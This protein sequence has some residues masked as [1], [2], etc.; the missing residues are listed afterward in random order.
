M[1][2]DIFIQAG[3]S[4]NE[5]IIYEYLLGSGQSTVG[6]IIKNTPI[7]RGLAYNILN[8]LKEKGLVVE[9]DK[10]KIASFS[11]NHPEK[12]REYVEKKGE[13]AA[14]AKNILEANLPAISSTFNLVSGKPGVRY[15][16]GLDGVKKAMEDTLTAKSEIRT[17]IDMEVTVKYIDKLN[18]QY[19]EKREKL[20][21]SK[22]IIMVE[23]E[24]SRNYLKNYHKAVTDARFIDG[25]LPQ[26]G[27]AIQIYDNKVSFVNLDENKKIAVIIEDKSIYETQK[28]IFDFVWEKSRPVEN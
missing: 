17:Y 19:A 4:E 27:S 23:S 18:R 24:F 28:T 16:E 10:S 11:A 1:Y 21:I 2:Q 15:F 12:L 25:N 5:A 8:G 14:K 7:K 13:E 20:G 9:A 6:A 22:K 26:F 3:L